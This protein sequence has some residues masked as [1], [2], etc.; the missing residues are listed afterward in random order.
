M[1][2]KHYTVSTVLLFIVLHNLIYNTSNGPLHI[3]LIDHYTN[4]KKTALNIIGIIC[5]ENNTN[6][7]IHSDCNAYF[8]DIHQYECVEKAKQI[9]LTFTG[10]FNYGDNRL[11]GNVFKVDAHLTCN[12]NNW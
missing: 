10:N 2:V 7:F 9:S 5:I 8:N 6:F 1:N 11:T 3:Q 4:Q 12:P